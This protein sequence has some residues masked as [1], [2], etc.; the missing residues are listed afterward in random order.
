[1]KILILGAF[2]KGAMELYYVRGLKNEGTD[3]TTFDIATPYY[4]T[5]DRSVINKVIN[6]LSPAI[7]YKPVNKALVQFVQGKKYDVIL[8]FKGLTLFPQTI[9]LL[10]EHARLLCCYNPDH[11]YKFFSEGSGNANIADS[12]SLYDMYFTYAVQV[13]NDLR[14]L[15]KV[16]AYTIP[17]GYDDTAPV[18]AGVTDSDIKSKWLFIGAF[19][20]ERAAFLHQLGEENLAIYGDAK[21]NSRNPFNRFIKAAYKGRAIYDEEYKSTVAA[22]AGVFNLLRQQNIEERSHNMRTFEVPGYGG[23]LISNRTEEQSAFYEEDREAVFFDSIDELKDKLHYLQ[24]HP[25]QIEKMKAAALVR[26]QRSNYSY[27]HRSRE[28]Y[29]IWSTNL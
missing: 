2:G 15:Y 22:G 5:L 16:N 24:A 19:D 7:F 28:M 25:N 9:K 6:K 11:P 12:I 13:T 20:N 21:W 4:E 14:K 23:L 17:F 18:H 10:K 26:S 27:Q 8:V 29:R 3:I 1:M